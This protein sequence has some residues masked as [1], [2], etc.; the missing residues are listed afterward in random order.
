MFQH[1]SGFVEIYVSG[2]WQKELI[3]A[4]NSVCHAAPAKCLYMHSLYQLSTPM[5]TCSNESQTVSVWVCL[6]SDY[7]LKQ[8]KLIQEL[9]MLFNR[10]VK[11]KLSFYHSVVSSL[12]SHDFV[13]FINLL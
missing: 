1:I 6:L 3:C 12:L 7:Y 9:N 4:V 5:S 2:S 13:L 10:T 11:I 8:V